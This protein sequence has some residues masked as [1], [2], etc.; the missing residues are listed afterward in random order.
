[1]DITCGGGHN[2]ALK[3][4]G[5]VVAWG[6]NADGQCA[7][8]PSLSGVA[9]MS[10]GGYHSLAVVPAALATHT[11]TT[12][13]SVP[14]SWL[15]AYPAILAAAGGDY[16]AAALHTTGKTGSDGSP[17]PVWHDYVAGTDPTD[18]ASV[19]RCS[20]EMVDGSPVVGWTP[21]LGAARVYTIWGKPDLSSSW[22]TPTDSAT[23]FFRVSV[24][25]P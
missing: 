24:S 9:S 5:T 13:V 18:P 12:P 17:L 21:D 20:I 7:V 11:I 8:P 2:L 15:D 23:R 3:S 25:L 16:E 10:G 4:G 6:D 14:Y 19:F 1:M 22:A